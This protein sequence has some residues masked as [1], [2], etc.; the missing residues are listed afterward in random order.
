MKYDLI[1][2]EKLSKNNLHKKFIYDERLDD[3]SSISSD[4]AD[5]FSEENIKFSLKLNSTILPVEMWGDF[6]YFLDDLIGYVDFLFLENV[7]SFV[8][9][10]SNQ[11]IETNIDFHKNREIVNITEKIFLKSSYL[12]SLRELQKDIVFFFDKL[13]EL[14]EYLIPNMKKN[15]WFRNWEQKIRDKMIDSSNF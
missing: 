6:P 2:E 7:N 10:L 8:Y 4:I 5:I 9:Y 14:I 1:L 13:M 15:I 12:I 11:G 3:F